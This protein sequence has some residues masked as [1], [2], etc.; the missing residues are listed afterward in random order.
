MTSRIRGLLV[1]TVGSAATAVFAAMALMAGAP[2]AQAATPF[3]VEKFVAANCKAGHEGCGEEEREAKFEPAPKVEIKL[4]Y[5]YPKEPNTTEAR[6]A[7]YTQAAGHPAVGITAFKVNTEGT[8][9]NEAPAGIATGGVVTHVRTDVAPGVST[10]PEAVEQCSFKDFGEESA[11]LKGSGLY[12]APACGEASEIGENKVV[13]WAGPKPFPEG[14]DLPLTGKVY[15]L[16]QPEGLASDFGVALPLPKELTEAKLNAIFHGSQPGIEKAQYYAHTLIEGSVE[17]AGNYHDYYEIKVSPELPLIASRL[18]LTGDIG[19]TGHGGFITNPSNCAGPGP[20]TTNTV[21][22]KSL[23]SQEGARTYT[24]PI[25][26]EG[27]NGLPP[28]ALVPFAPTFKV[29]PETTQSDKPT[30][31]TADLALPHDPSPTGI[32]SSQLRTATV[33]LPEGMTLNPSAATGLKACTPAQIGIGTRNPVTC[34]IESRLGTVTLTVPDLPAGEPLTGHMYLGG[35]EPITGGSN[36]AQPE[37]TMYVVAE[38]TRYGVSVRLQGTVKPNPT[39]GQVTTVFENNPEQPFSNIKLKFKG[40]ALAPIANPLTCGTATTSA[41]FVPYTG[42]P[43]AISPLVPTFAVDSNGTGGACA[44]PLPFVLTQSTE[45]LPTTGGAATSFTF[46]LARTDG[47]Q[48]LSHVTTALPPGLLGKIPTAVQCPE[49]QASQ[50]VCSAESRIGTVTTTAGAGGAPV[51][52]SGVVY[53][54]G[55]YAGAPFG[56]VM[57]VPA[58][59][60]PFS[61]GNVIVRSKIEINPYTSQVTVSSEVPTIFK[62]IPLRMKTLSLTINGQGF[63]VNPTNCAAFSTATTLTSSGGASQSLSTPFQATNCSALAFA[64]KFGA[65]TNAKTSRANGASLVTNVNVPAGGANF[66]SVLVTVPKQ[67]PSRLSTLK[68]ACVEATFNANPNLCP[69]NSKVGTARIKTPLLP[70][71]LSG[72]AYFV[73]HGGAAFPDLDLVLTGDNVRVI[74]VGNTNI[75]KGVTTTNFAS[76]PDAPFT[77]F[78][79]NLPTGPNSA[80]AAN[81]NLCKQSLVMP[82]TITAQNGK[83]F[84][85]NTKI[86][87][88]GCPVTVVSHTSKKGKAVVVVRAPEAGRVSGGGS[89]LKTVYKYPS[90][91]QNVTLE[92]PLKTSR[93]PVTV[94]VRVGFTPKAKGKKSSTAYATV[95]V[96]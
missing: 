38:T 66:K 52:F 72:P 29:E 58:T 4:K 61:L 42:N 78:E 64:P 24:T 10:N 80:V 91:Q 32:D 49:P 60:G 43:A 79:L 14:G 5:S 21:T 27:C 86:N 93:R 55:P 3:G 71:Q 33:T 15:N 1:G 77:G 87:V 30:G 8:F 23:A 74:L 7:G 44:S 96:K 47:Q 85:Q 12:P 6:E 84:K 51:Q 59:V 54:T 46:N 70:G 16:E 68:N 73:S 95:R 62:G 89:S 25:G 53:L 13:I 92:V 19:T 88:T 41:T 67:L 75:S 17:W 57:V 34:P 40:G 39:T 18:S 20:L 35:T 2:A 9:P 22:L 69:A 76:T 65:T 48:Y 11:L 45:S 28:F 82:T 36:P 63:L 94:R 81:G 83:V 50:G 31:V 56:M 37:Y 26:T 90:K